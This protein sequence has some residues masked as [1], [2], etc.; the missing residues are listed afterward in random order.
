MVSSSNLSRSSS[1]DLKLSDHVLKMSKHD[2]RSSDNKRI[3]ETMIQEVKKEK[4]V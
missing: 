4:E 1:D 3:K 2:S